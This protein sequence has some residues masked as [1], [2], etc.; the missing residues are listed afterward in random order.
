MKK[1]LLILLA[2]VPTVFNLRASDDVT[3]EASAQEVVEVGE[4]FQVSFTVNASGTNFRGPQFN[5]FRLITGPNTM[6][7]QS[8][9]IIN[10]QY[11]SVISLSYSYVIQALE[12]GEFT[13]AAASIFVEGKEYKSN[14]LKIKVI[15]S[16]GNSQSNNQR[17]SRQNNKQ[18]RQ[19]PSTTDHKIKNAFIEA[20]VNKA[21]PY[22]GEEVIVTYTLYYRINIT[23]G[24]TSKHLFPG[25]YS[26]VL[27][28]NN[29]I[30]PETVVTRNGV[31]YYRAEIKKVALFPQ[32][33]GEIIIEPLEFDCRV[34]DWFRY[35]VVT[36]KA[37]EIK[38]DV[39]PLPLKGKPV[40]FSGAV[41]YFNLESS[42]DKTKLAVNDALSLK[43]TIKGKGNLELIDPMLI[44]FPP[45]FEVYDPKITN[46]INASK[47]GVMGSRTFEYLI[48]PRNP[49][50]FEID[51]ISFKYF[52]PSKENYIIEETPAYKI[53]VEKGDGTSSNVTY[54][55]VSQEDVQY[56]GQDVHHI[57]TDSFQLQ[58]IGVYFFNSL[59]FYLFIFIPLAL[60]ILLILIWKT[61]EKKQQNIV[62]MKNKRATRVAKQNLKKAYRF[63]NAG[64]NEIFYVEISRA[65]WGYIGDKFNIKQAEFS[66]ESVEDTLSDKGVENGIIDQFI[67]TLNNTEYARFA[68]GDSTSKM[69]NIYDEALDIISKI[70]RQL[71]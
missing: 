66:M 12:E 44:T 56:I 1:Y 40:N 38:I 60:M 30:A 41:G 46:N 54:S 21:D 23:R 4:R 57:M 45:D 50:E 18:G 48:V 49:G 64:E 65:L 2:V 6:N 42:V 22:L 68:P 55:G 37:N 32:K 14:P 10:N 25:F 43:I 33:T 59:S 31:Q 51:P 7:S 47:R 24:G 71:K 34:E 26:K 20:Q 5:N 27:D 58:R 52:D 9:Q 19:Y 61:R 15:P 16:T 35:N 17:Q 62:L 69:K 67:A 63:L 11:K 13:I 8:T 28:E 39:K 36:L 3:F 53:T 70:E 29:N